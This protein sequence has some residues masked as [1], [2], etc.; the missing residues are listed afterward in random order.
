M[1][2]KTKSEKDFQN[3]KDTVKEIKLANEKEERIEKWATLSILS[4]ITTTIW[5][6]ILI[7]VSKTLSNINILFI[8]LFF[9]FLISVYMVIWKPFEEK[10]N[11]PIKG[12]YLISL[13]IV[14]TTVLCMPTVMLYI[15][16]FGEEL[17]EKKAEEK[18]GDS[19]AELLIQY[20]RLDTLVEFDRRKWNEEKE[21]SITDQIRD[22]ENRLTAFLAKTGPLNSDHI[23]IWPQTELLLQEVKQLIEKIKA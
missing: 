3:L 5:I 2:K 7:L 8:V 6:V 1:T 16:C 20:S 19:R 18:L 4:V 10:D 12:I 21:Q 14:L 11:D 22:L 15:L 13:T 9:N 17:E 23:I